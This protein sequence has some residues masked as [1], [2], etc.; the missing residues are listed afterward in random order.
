MWCHSITIVC[1]PGHSVISSLRRWCERMSM[2]AQVHM[3]VL[4]QRAVWKVRCVCVC[5]KKGWTRA[6]VQGWETDEG[7]C[8]RGA[9]C[10]AITA[11]ITMIQPS[12][13]VTLH[14][15]VIW[16]GGLVCS[17]WGAVCLNAADISVV[18]K[19]RIMKVLWFQS[20]YKGYWGTSRFWLLLTRW[21][22]ASSWLAWP[23]ISFWLM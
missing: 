2:T 16:G 13:L 18:F 1:L 12:L 19:T 20:L 11:Q 21:C 17:S 22:Q 14:K 9:M 4:S 10:S 6:R 3:L 23:R 8:E 5:D 15:N 7:E